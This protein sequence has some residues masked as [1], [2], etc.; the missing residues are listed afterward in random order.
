MNKILLW[1]KNILSLIVLS[2]VISYIFKFNM[3]SLFFVILYIIYLVLNIKDIFKKDKIIY[4]NTYNIISILNLLLIGFVFLRTFIDQG[5]IYNSSEYALYLDSIGN[6]ITHID[7]AMTI[8]IDYINQNMVWLIISLLL[9]LTYRYLNN[10]HKIK[11]HYST[12]L[13]LFVISIISIVFSIYTLLIINTRYLDAS[14]AAIYL[15]MTLCL[16]GINIYRYIQGKYKG[17]IWMIISIIAL[18]LIGLITCFIN[19]HY[20]FKYWL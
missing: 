18:H 3:T 15:F 2:L 10:D 7:Q 12:T 8:I 4:N 20:A 6:N 17:K 9:I 16:I 1:I 19:L 14:F 5:F 11:E 13:L